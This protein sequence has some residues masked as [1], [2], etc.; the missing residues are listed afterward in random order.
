MI[1]NGCVE[2]RGILQLDDHAFS[3]CEF[4]FGTWKLAVDHEHVTLDT[5]WCILVPCDGEIK[6]TSWGLLA[7]IE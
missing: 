1:M 3:F 4:Y 2:R 6:I 5:I 7:W